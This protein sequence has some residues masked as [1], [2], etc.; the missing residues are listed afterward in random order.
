[1]FETAELGRKVGKSTYKSQIP[2]LRQRLVGAQQRL[3]RL[4]RPV[5]LVFGG[6]DGAGKTDTVS[7]LYEWM[8]PRWILTHAYEAPLQHEAERPRMWRYWRDLPPRGQIGV[9]LSAWYHRPLVARALEGHDPSSNDDLDEIVAFER[10]LDA[11]GAIIVKI[12]LHLGREQQRERFDELRADPLQAWRVSERDL[13]NLERYDAFVDAA[14]EL[15]GRTSTAQAPWHIVEGADARYRELEVARIFLDAVEANTGR[16]DEPDPAQPAGSPSNGTGDTS[17]LRDLIAGQPTILSHIEMPERLPGKEYRQQLAQL[18]SRIS[19]LQRRAFEQHVPMT[20][21]FEGPDAAGKGGVIRR[22]TGPLDP[23]NY[24]VIP[25]AGPTD[26]ERAHQYLWRFWRHLPRSG[27]LAIF[28]RSWYGRVLVERVEEF[29][30]EDEWRRAYA[31]I[32]LFE[33]QLVDSEYVLLKFWMHVT[34]DEQLRRFEERKATPHKR[35]KL[36]DE[37]WRNREKWDDYARAA[38][39]MIE[40]TSTRR[41][42]WV[43]VPANDKPSARIAVLA[44]VCEALEAR[45]AE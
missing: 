5:I 36:T 33:R 18:Q 40:R 26:E 17:P 11:D 14:E 10:M 42:P 24:K 2:A 3:R 4:E 13:A 39:D 41:S 9:F 45:V 6:V 21:V 31:E 38:H 32:N 7:R 22:L 43:I 35:W 29:A 12:W 25:I 30:T 44:R 27:R 8:D 20:L 16:P 15:L 37:D 1:M 28:D 23:R 34:E 19:L